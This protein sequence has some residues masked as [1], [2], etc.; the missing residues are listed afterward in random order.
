M[1]IETI[2]PI[3]LEDLKK[4]FVDK[5]ITFLIDY[6]NSKIQGT[7]LLTYIS[8]LD[9][10]ID[11]KFDPNDETGQSLL[12]DYMQSSFLVNV[13]SLEVATINKLL[14]YKFEPTKSPFIEK[15]QELLEH[16][17]ILL[18]SATLYNFY[19]L[20]G[21]PEL[22]DWV[23]SFPAYNLEVVKGI[24]FVQ[25]FKYQ[26]FY[27]FYQK[28]DESK[29]RYCPEVF[30]DYIFKGNNLFHYWS[31]E[32][33]IMFMLTWGVVNGH[34]TAQNFAEMVDHTKMEIENATSI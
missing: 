2:A 5:T 10:P 3:G 1:I 27:Q 22:K 9:I 31:N 19:C 4:Y 13:P 34:V 21:A 24:N 17:T 32:N 26:E 6:E 29:L 8:N 15:N 16:W 12:E 30:K 7:K 14:E 20:N 23:E 18:D 33:N 25:L 11:V 28:V